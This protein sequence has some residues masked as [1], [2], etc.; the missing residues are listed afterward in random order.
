LDAIGPGGGGVYVGAGVVA[1]AV[2]G[3][4]AQQEKS[5]LHA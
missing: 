2:G 5:S 3:K 1:Q 4:H